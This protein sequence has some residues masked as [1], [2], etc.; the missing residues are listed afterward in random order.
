MLFFQRVHPSCYTVN[1]GFVPDPLTGYGAPMGSN[2]VGKD[3]RNCNHPRHQIERD[4]RRK[5]HHHHFQHSS[6]DGS[7]LDPVQL[8]KL[9]YLSSLP[10]S[11]I[12]QHYPK[13]VRIVL[14]RN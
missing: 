7:H 9:D 5:H 3:P 1:L 13:K 10:T 14:N 4:N 8:E 12:K 11:Y 2:G 6:S